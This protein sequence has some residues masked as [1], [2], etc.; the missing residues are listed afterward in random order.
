MHASPFLPE[1]APLRR[2]TFATLLLAALAAPAAAQV[3]YYDH[4]PTPDEIAAALTAPKMQS[5]SAKTLPGQEQDASGARPAAAQIHSRGLTK[6]RDP[7]VADQIASGG[8]AAAAPSAS[9]GAGP[10]IALPVVFD[11]GS[12]HIAANSVPFIQAMV[13]V[14]ERDPSL[15]LVIEGHTDAVGVARNNLMLSW[16]RAYSVF[17]LMV[18]RYGIDPARLQPLGKGS[19]EPL[20]DKDPMDGANR[21]VQFRVM[22]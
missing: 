4:P 13:A 14:L 7:P 16:D 8:Q 5:P 3:K 21:R 22:G 17:R 10:A 19:T 9:A 6:R 1:R 20:S 11:S 12:A 2:A 15:R 18:E